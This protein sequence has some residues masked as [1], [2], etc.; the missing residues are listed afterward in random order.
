MTPTEL[1]Y[2][3]HNK[4]LLAIVKCVAYWRAYLKEAK[5]T[6]QVV[7]D[8]KNLIYFTTTKK[9]TRRQVR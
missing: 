7:T 9:L 4:E 8:H 5:Y 3:V 1:N 2:N 6:V